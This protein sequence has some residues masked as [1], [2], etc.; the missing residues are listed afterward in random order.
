MVTSSSFFFLTLL[1]YMN[2][3]LFHGNRFGRDNFHEATKIS[4]RV[5]HSNI[6]WT[7]FRYMAFD[8]PNHDGTYEERYAV[9]G[10]STAKSGLTLFVD[11]EI[12]NN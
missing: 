5:S 10:K 1:Y 12:E 2:S 7:K 3:H 9:L 11:I 4:Y 6:D 8:I